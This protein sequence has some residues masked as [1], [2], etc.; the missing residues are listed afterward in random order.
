MSLGDIPPMR[1]FDLRSEIL[2]VPD[3]SATATK[4]RERL[5]HTKIKSAV[6]AAEFMTD[7]FGELYA[8][9]TKPSHEAF[10][11]PAND[12]V[13]AA[14]MSD[15][16]HRPNPFQPLRPDQRPG[17][18]NAE[19]RGV[20]MTKH[21][22]GRVHQDGDGLPY[23]TTANLSAPIYFLSRSASVHLFKIPA[24]SRFVDGKKQD[25]K[26]RLGLANLVPESPAAMPSLD[27]IVE[28]EAGRLQ[29]GVAKYLT[30]LK[31]DLFNMSQGYQ[32]YDGFTVADVI[33]LWIDA[34]ARDFPDAPMHSHVWKQGQ[35]EPV[36]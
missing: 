33:R 8:V 28:V 21:Y 36:Q 2:D 7:F 18:L 22:T 4:A 31:L 30:S 35:W 24:H 5:N 15:M 29:W 14:R 23:T 10:L 11:R 17:R 16:S 13:Y 1:P 26:T 27:M 20:S 32:E 34:I 12:N 25:I 6:D 9:H 3:D 19:I